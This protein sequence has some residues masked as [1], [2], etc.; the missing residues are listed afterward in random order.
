MHNFS[1]LHY[2][3]E[4]KP[5]FLT[6]NT[7]WLEE[8]FSITEEDVRQLANPELILH[9]GGSVLFVEFQGEII[10]TCALTWLNDETIEL[11]KMGV[12]SEFR[13]KGAGHFLLTEAEKEAAKMG[14][15]YL[16][17][18]TAEILKP[19]ISLYLKHGFK[20]VGEE[21]THPMFG[22]K[23]FEMRKVIDRSMN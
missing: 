15:I 20:R 21:Y 16:Q 4:L 1:L 14:G 7:E 5:Y 22:R 17:L 10:A 2:S 13:R 8:Y 23:V 12:K 11:I 18:E 9:S 6:L 19:A 3:A